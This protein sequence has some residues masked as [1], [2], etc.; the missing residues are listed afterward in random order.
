M[1]RWLILLLAALSTL[2]AQAETYVYTG[3]SYG[4]AGTITNQTTCAPPQDC[5]Q[6]TN[7]QR[8]TGYITTAGPLG[9]NLVNA[10][11]I[12]SITGYSFSNGATT[13]ASG[14]ASRLAQLRV[15]TDGT[16][17]ITSADVTLQR[18]TYS[19]AASAPAGPHADGDELDQ[20]NVLGSASSFTFTTGFCPGGNIGA[21]FDGTA[22]VCLSAGTSTATS[23]AS[24]PGGAWSAAPT[25]SIN[26]VSIAEGNAGV[27]SM[28]FTVTLSAVPTT[29]VSMSVAATPVTA[30]AGVDYALPFLSVSWAPG[31]AATKTLSVLVQG[32]TAVE[33]DETFLLTLS[34][35]EG[36]T[37]GTAVGTG[38]ILNDDVLPP[39]GATS[40]PTLSEWALALLA[41][42]SA[43]LGLR[44][45]RRCP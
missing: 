17:A 14:S 29:A 2:G 13:I 16:G 7:A 40:I 18:W 3:G 35:P 24:A 4:A 32:D 25:V 19:A 21:S 30:T 33:P 20:I 6:F 38:T 42:A 5:S 36:A 39:A 45:L 1:L 15:F 28:D 8:I 37:L 41:L 44:Q 27:A 23:L 34:N 26:S 12:P 9:N 31:D 22:D 10:N 11:I 43:A